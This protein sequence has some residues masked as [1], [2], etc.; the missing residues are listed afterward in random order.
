M[1]KLSFFIRCLTVDMVELTN[2]VVQADLSCSINLKHLANNTR[3]IKYDPG[4]FTGAI[5][6]HRLI[7]GNCLVFHNGK[8]NCNGNKSIHQA[9]K[10][11][12]Q[13]ARLLQ[14]H[15][16]QVTLKKIE[17]ITMSAVHRLSSTLELKE[18]SAMLGAEYNPEILNAAILKK[19]RINNRHHRHS[20][21][22]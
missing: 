3:D 22:A 9:K 21:H 5:W 20:V 18:V 19:K 11:L 17:L 8:V 4:R 14:R 16:F 12:R 15:G 6:Q 10:R 2:V 13:Y 7:G 1:C